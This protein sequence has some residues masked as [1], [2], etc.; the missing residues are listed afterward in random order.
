[1]RA[2]AA[3]GDEAG[4]L[5]QAEIFAAFYEA[6]FG[7]A[8]DP[9][10]GAL[11]ARIRRGELRPAA[12]EPNPVPAPVAQPIADVIT[13]AA[14][15]PAPPAR[16]QVPPVHDVPLPSPSVAADAGA[17]TVTSGWAAVALPTHPGRR[18]HR[19]APTFTS[20]TCSPCFR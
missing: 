15:V 8:P 20:R 17:I 14:S 13:P 12:A 16:V 18:S 10:I 7:V 5:R 11:A 4:A 1:M 9:R 6:E 2:Q 3:A 19:G